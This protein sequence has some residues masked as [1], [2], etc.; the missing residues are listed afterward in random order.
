VESQDTLVQAPRLPRD[1]AA[2]P[3]R[4]RILEHP[5]GG[6]RELVLGR[7]RLLERLGSGGFGVVWRARDE[8][9]HREVALKRVPL[10]ADGGP[11]DGERASREALAAARLAHPAIVALHEAC[12]HEQSFYLISEL[13]HGDTLARLIAADALE[14]EEILEIGAALASALAHAHARGVIHRDIKPQNVLVP[15]AGEGADGAHAP[16][17]LTDFGGAALVGEEVLTRT[18]DVVGTLAYMAPEQSEG[19]EA[20]EQADLYSLALVLYEALTG[21]NPIRGAT[22]ALTARRLGRPL[23]PLARSRGDL[24]PALTAALDR[25]LEVRPESRGELDDLRASLEHALATGLRRRA[26]RRA[27]RGA[28]AGGPEEPDARTL[29]APP[30]ARVPVRPPRAA[31]RVAADAAGEDAAPVA[32]QA[33]AVEPVAAPSRLALPRAAWL[34]GA[35]TLVGWQAA[36]GRPGVAL[37]LCAALVPLLSLPRARA[38]RGLGFWWLAAA[39]AP[40]LGCIGLAGAFPALAGQGSRWRERAALAAL[41]YWWLTLA[42]PLLA[43]SLW[44]AIPAG[45]P[46]RGAWESSIAQSASHVLAPSFTVAVLCGT[47]LW[48]AGAA[49]LP[50]LVRGSSAARDL[51]AASAWAAAL[52]AAEPSVDAGLAAHAAHPDPRGAVLGAVLGA[53]VA[54]AARALRGPV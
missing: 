18:G 6:E 13:V 23:P 29:Q 49:T 43:R 32:A 37:L 39:L 48:A 2:A 41:G 44:L 17:K 3:P 8:L 26:W 11:I 19:R 42:G 34:A 50:W 28:H 45:T 27:R 47:L 5:G 53:L 54:V 24:P 12:A 15:Y 1:A 40:A 7:Y 25:A 52:A 35:L 33:A 16:A 21:E 36:S 51:L 46:P 20:G 9:L 10:A 38:G 4:K 14:D 22:P 30:R 31:T